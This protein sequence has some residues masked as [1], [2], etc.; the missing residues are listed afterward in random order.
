MMPGAT[1]EE[2]IAVL[3]SVHCQLR[4]IASR[5]EAADIP[6]E[7]AVSA[8]LDQAASAVLLAGF[9][10]DL[11]AA[12]AAAEPSKLSDETARIMYALAGLTTNQDETK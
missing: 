8:I 7:A 3:M 5:M 11:E 4:A 9:R 10:L 12:R 1:K 6:K 2:V